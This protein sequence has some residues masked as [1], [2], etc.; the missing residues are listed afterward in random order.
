MCGLFGWFSSSIA[1]QDI[2]KFNLLMFLSTTRGKDS[3]GVMSVIR[4]GQWKQEKDVRYHF[5]KSPIPAWDFQRLNDYNTL[6][7]LNDIKGL[8][9]HARAA[10][11]G[12]VNSDNAHPFESPNG[13]IIGAHN[14]TLTGEYPF[15]EKDKTDSEAIMAIIEKDGLKGLAKVTGAWALTFLDTVN[16]TFNLIRNRDRPLFYFQTSYGDFGYASEKWMLRALQDK[17]NLT[18]EIKDLEPYKLLSFDL[19]EERYL[20]DGMSITDV[21]GLEAPKAHVYNSRFQGYR[22]AYGYTDFDSETDELPLVW[23]NPRNYLADPD[24]ASGPHS[25]VEKAS[26]GVSVAAVGNLGGGKLIEEAQQKREKEAQVSQKEKEST[27]GVKTSNVVGFSRDPKGKFT[28]STKEQ[29]DTG[30]QTNDNRSLVAAAPRLRDGNLPFLRN[31]KEKQRMTGTG[32]V[33]VE[34]LKGNWVPMEDFLLMLEYGACKWT[35]ESSEVED[36]RYWLNK[37]EWISETAWEDPEIQHMYGKDP[38]VL[39]SFLN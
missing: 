30:S 2:E 14:G 26:N 17:Y 32:A 3:T 28:S 29:G 23:Q 7:R 27:A 24:A 19:M 6:V 20:M 12:S 10:T 5:L 15:K 16:N 8:M 9:G 36:T 38:S 35:N 34:T 1:Q 18:G 21:E 37:S 22:G 33:E 13:Q 4:H 39:S 31:L 11:I 25:R